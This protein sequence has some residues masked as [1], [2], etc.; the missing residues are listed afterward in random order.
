MA[1]KKTKFIKKIAKV[2]DY[3]FCLFV[4]LLCFVALLF[5]I[6]W[7]LKQ[8]R[9]WNRSV[10]GNPKAL[11]LRKFKVKTVIDLGDGMLL[12]Y[13]NPS[14]TWLG[15]LD[16]SNSMETHVRVTD[17]LYLITWK[18][19]NIIRFLKKTKFSA[20]S[21]ILREFIAVFKITSFCVGQEVG[22]LRAY[23]PDYPALQALLVSIFI[24]I[25]YMVDV[26]GNFELIRRLAGK[27]F[28][29]RGL[30]NLPVIRIFARIGANWLLGLPLR[31][32]SRVLG[33]NKNNYEHAFALGAPVERLSLLRYSNFSVAYNSYN[34]E[35][36]PSKPADYPYILFVGRLDEIKFPLDPLDAFELAAPHLPEYRLVIIGDGDLREEMQRKKELS[37]YKDRIMFLGVQ[38]ND[39]VFSWTAHA[40]IA[41][42]PYSGSTLVE[43][44]LCGIPVIAYDVE[45][46]A[47]VAI[48]NYTGFLVPFRDITAMG[49]KMIRVANNYEDSRIV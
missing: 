29:F 16:A 31:H 1:K 41:I 26:A 4:I 21:I 19:P 22:V 25:P 45:W 38:S 18:S 14:I 34:P 8:R 36:P 20:T 40:K 49:E 7:I 3:P 42:C 23:K 46:H 48:D 39:A 44:M 24:K 47:E 43:A 17:D 6:P 15:F 27:V 13:R 32:A 30:Y 2:L 35:E 28:Y 10:K 33:R 37:L 12:P 9:I 11:I 5:A